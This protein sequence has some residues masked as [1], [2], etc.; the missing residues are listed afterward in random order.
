MHLPGV[1]A[2]HRYCGH[3]SASFQSPL[4][5]LTL[6]PLGMCTRLLHRTETTGVGVYQHFSEYH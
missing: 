1:E 2:E 4:T 5:Y 3:V 6:G